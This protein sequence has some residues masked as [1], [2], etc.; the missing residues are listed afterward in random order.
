MIRV[1]YAMLNL[2]AYRLVIHAKHD[3]FMIALF[4]LN[5]KYSAK[6]GKSQQGL[7]GV[8]L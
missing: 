4:A 2:I 5:S 6:S 3:G 8:I 7:G 1:E